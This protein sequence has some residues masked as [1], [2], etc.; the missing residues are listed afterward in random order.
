[1]NKS[2]VILFGTESGNAEFAAEDMA[3]E[4]LE[5]PVVIIDMSD[6]DVN[7]F[8]S[9]N[10]YLIVC[11]T[12]GEGDLPSGAL[13]MYEALE[14]INPDLTG[15]GYAVF[16]LG[17]SSYENYSNGSKHIDVKLSALGARRVGE[18]GR[19]DAATGTLPSA[20]AVAWAKEI[21]SA[22]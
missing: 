13:P 21:L 5:R 14:S 20:R 11:S 9:E 4:I 10:L 22:Y 6:F 2:I 18:Y 12:H 17:D 8:S 19:H 1:M 7:S 3:A 16:G 15:I